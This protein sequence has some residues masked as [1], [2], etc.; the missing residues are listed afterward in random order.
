MTVLRQR[1]KNMILA[2]L[3]GFLLALVIV[4]MIYIFGVSNNPKVIQ[5]FLREHLQSIQ[6]T[7]EDK[8]KN[9][10]H[11]LEKVYVFKNS[12]LEN[13]RI[14]A[15]DFSEKMID[16]TLVPEQRIL[17]PEDLIGKKLKCDASLNMIATATM[18]YEEKEREHVKESVEVMDIKVPEFI[19]DADLINLRIHYPTGHDYLVLENATLS[20]VYEERQGATL[21]LNHDEIISLSSAKEDVNLYPGTLL[22]Y[23]KHTQRYLRD[24][25]GENLR[26][27]Y[28]VNPNTIG[29]LTSMYKAEEV[30]HERLLLDEMLRTFFDQESHAYSFAHIENTISNHKENQE[31]LEI[32]EVNSQM[33]QPQETL[34]SS[35]EGDEMVKDGLEKQGPEAL[36]E[37]SVGF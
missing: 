25:I 35:V 17:H 33:Q 1:H 6:I 2:G 14:T 10:P 23:T 30:Y 5:W 22:Y 32:D 16:Q 20:K 15:E 31:R 37:H 26:N 18:V 27:Q 13:D 19:Q 28:P 12:L 36:P 3:V 8:E 11:A 24:Y 4:V 21:H 34:E 7:H 9:P 29:F